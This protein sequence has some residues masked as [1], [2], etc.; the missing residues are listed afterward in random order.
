MIINHGNKRQNTCKKISFYFI[1]FIN[2]NILKLSQE[3]YLRFFSSLEVEPKKRI[4]I[5]YCDFN[6]FTPNMTSKGMR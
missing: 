6:S 4:K 3:I 5:K 2:K 1:V